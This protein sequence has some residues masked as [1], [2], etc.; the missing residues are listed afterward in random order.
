MGDCL[1]KLKGTDDK[2]NQD[3]AHYEDDLEFDESLRNRSRLDAG[4]GHGGDSSAAGERLR[5][6]KSSGLSKYSQDGLH[7]VNK[8][9]CIGAFNVQR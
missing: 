1:T 9:I 8:P 2:E 3:P 6:R 5:R 4:V 7:V